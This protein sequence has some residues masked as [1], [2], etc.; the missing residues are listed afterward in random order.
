[1]QEGSFSFHELTIGQFNHLKSGSGH[2]SQYKKKTNKKTVSAPYKT[3]IH[4]NMRTTTGERTAGSWGQDAVINKD[5]AKV[6]LNK[7]RML[8][9][10]CSIY[11]ADVINTHKTD[12][13]LKLQTY[14]RVK[15]KTTKERRLQQLHFT[16][17]RFNVNSNAQIHLLR[18]WVLQVSLNSCR[19]S[20]LSIS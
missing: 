15:L 19:C 1:M 20:G 14:S 5:D 13:K 17:R 10:Q 8:Q 2:S 7:Y 9:L 11:T 16:I 4:L 6:W 3:F 12:Q 18:V